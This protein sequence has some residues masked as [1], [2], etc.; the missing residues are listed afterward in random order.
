MSTIYVTRQGATVQRREGR[1]VICD[2]GETLETIPESKVNRIVISGNVNITTPVISHCLQQ[3]I[4]VV[5]LTQSGRF[6]GRL[7]GVGARQSERRMKQYDTYRNEPASFA[8]ARSIVAGKIRNQIAVASRNGSSS[9]REFQTLRK[10]LA[11]AEACL[12]KNELLGIEG[13]A[14]AAYFRAFA[15]WIP[16]PFVFGGRSSNPPRDEVNAV[17]SLAYTLVYNR[18]E[19]CLHLTGLDVFLG[20]LH[21]PRNGHAALASDLCEEFRTSF[22]DPLVLRLFRRRQIKPEHFERRAGK[23]LLSKEGL[24]LFFREFEVKLASRRRHGG[25]E[26]VAFSEIMR[27]QA[28]AL[29]RT[30]EKPDIAY[31]PFQYQAAK[32]VK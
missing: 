7:M 15:G 28:M 13:A 2:G 16:K 25:D 27:R 20:F 29:A 19:S 17:L 18:L 9:D 11:R 30:I 4:E 10:M 24:A 23:I 31:R 12:E 3:D 26:E 21:C 22:C 8:I 5:F 1:F 6:K 32:E 14:S